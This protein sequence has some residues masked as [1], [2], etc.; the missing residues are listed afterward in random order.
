MNEIIIKQF[1][2]YQLRYSLDENGKEWFV[3]KDVCDA[4]GIKNVSHAVKK[5][6]KINVRLVSNDM[7]S[8]SREFNCVNRGGLYTLILQS[9]KPSAIRYQEW[10]TDEVLV[11]I[12]S[13]GSYSIAKKE[14][15]P[16]DQ[17]KMTIEVMDRQRQ[18]I[19]V[20]NLNMA[21][22]EIEA[23]QENDTL[24][25]D[26]IAELDRAMY[27]RFQSFKIKDKKAYGLMK[28]A[29]KDRFFDIKGTRT[30]KEIKRRDFQEALNIIKTFPKPQYLT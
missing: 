6:K 15:D 16:L 26:Q 24:T 23:K 29:I 7:G 3:A 17:L 9:R 4:L 25:A 20:L 1:E 2:G 28:K 27:E 14:L 19:R 8:V 21:R 5:I 22:V 11:D 13:K 18:E 12:H 10:V 30:Y